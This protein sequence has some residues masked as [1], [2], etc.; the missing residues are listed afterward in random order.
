MRQM[1]MEQL[2]PTHINAHK[3]DIVHILN[4]PVNWQQGGFIQMNQHKALL[5][6]LQSSKAIALLI[7][8]TSSL[9]AC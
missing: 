5:L 7:K 4:P 8:R 9:P 3:E 1:G 6:S 2:K